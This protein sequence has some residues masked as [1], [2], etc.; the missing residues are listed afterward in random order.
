MKNQSLAFSRKAAKNLSVAILVIASSF[1]FSFPSFAESLKELSLETNDFAV[2]VYR[3][4]QNNQLNINIWDIKN[5]SSVAN[6]QEIKKAEMTVS[7]D[8]SQKEEK[9]DENP[10]LEIAKIVLTPLSNSLS[11]FLLVVVLAWIIWNFVR[12]NSNQIIALLRNLNI[13]SIGVGEFFTLEFEQSISD[14][15][16]KQDL[17]LPSVNDKREIRDVVE[18]LAPL[19]EGKRILWV[20]DH[21]ENNH[22]EQAIFTKFKINVQSVRTSALAQQEL[23]ARPNYYDL[24][25]SDWNRDPQ[26]DPNKAEGL[27]FLEEIR[28]DGIEI[29]VIFYH[30]IVDEQ[31]L[32][33]RRSL[34]KQ[35]RAIGTTGSP[36]EL[37]KWTMAGLVSKSLLP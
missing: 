35:A 36:G 20:D 37:L 34:A 12:Q 25:I 6:A 8:V 10:W 28:A 13:R 3:Q 19:V 1:S 23:L 27:R 29:P 24:M 18:H 30:G 4:G 7:K 31:E 21:P 14:A 15:Y 2:K 11:V 26:Q 17:G 22:Q 5:K 33:Q 9:Q 32:N 16:V